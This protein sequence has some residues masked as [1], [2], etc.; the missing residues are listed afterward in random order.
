M[1]KRGKMIAVAE[2]WRAVVSFDGL[3]ADAYQISNLGNCRSIKRERAGRDGSIRAVK[4]K[5]L[6]PRIRENGTRAVNLWRGNTY[7]QV[8]V[9]QLVLEAWRGPC[10]DNYEP[11]NV[12]GDPSDNRLVNLA[13]RPAGGLALLRKRLGR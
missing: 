7:Q 2:R 9:K 12:N 4:G 3:Y 13:W 8:P 1:A 11:V 10:P 6:S 5:I